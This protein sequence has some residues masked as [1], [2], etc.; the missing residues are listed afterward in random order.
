MSDTTQ[1]H[2]DARA[3]IGT[4]AGNVWQYLSSNGEATPTKISK[5]T[6]ET[7]SRVNQA[8]GW[9]SCEGKVVLL[10]S[11]KTENYRLADRE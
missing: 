5:A 6:G 10:K 7:P 11:G 1:Q 8:L 9:L 3:V 2:L 4:S